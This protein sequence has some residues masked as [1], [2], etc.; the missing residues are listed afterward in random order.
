MVLA[1]LS[2]LEETCFRLSASGILRMVLTSDFIT[3]FFRS[4]CAVRLL[5]R[6]IFFFD[7]FSNGITCE[8][9]HRLSLGCKP[10]Y[11]IFYL[12]TFLEKYQK[13]F[14]RKVRTC[15]HFSFF[16]YTSCSQNL[17]FC[18]RQNIGLKNVAL[19][20]ETCRARG[21]RSETHSMQNGLDIY[22]FAIGKR[23]W[24]AYNHH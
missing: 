22:F 9:Y 16:D 10:I 15:S 14:C 20:C 3:C 8:V 4:F 17:V 1:A 12:S 7:D 5:S 19:Y 21:E 24:F 13:Q 6:R 11:Q 2:R 23:A 18:L